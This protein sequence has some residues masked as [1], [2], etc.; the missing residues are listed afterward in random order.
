VPQEERSFDAHALVVGVSAYDRIDVLPAVQDAPDVAAVLGDPALCAYPRERVE[1]LVDAAA[2]RDAILRGLD[3]LTAAAGPDASVF[4]YFSGHGGRISDDPGSDCYLMP[5]E[6][7]WRSA[8]DLERTAIAGRELSDRL[9]GIGAARITMVLD[10]CR[11]AG[12][13]RPGPTPPPSPLDGQLTS[14]D[15]A[16]LARGRGRVVLAASRADAV[17]Y[18]AAGARNSPFTANLLAGLRGKANGTGGVI[19]ICDL[20]DYVQQQMKAAKPP[21]IPV[22]KAELEEN[23]PVALHEGGVAPALVLP[24]PPDDCAFDAFVSYRRVAADRAWV[25]Q[26]L[27]PALERLGLRLCLPERDFRLG[28]PRIREMERAVETSRY[29]LGVFT[30]QYL[31]GAFE[32][33]QALMAQHQGIEDKAPRFLP[34]MREPCRPALGIRTVEWLDVSESALE[35]ATLSRLAL[36]LREPRRQPFSR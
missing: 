10:C 15:V 26:V 36:R 25:E 4:I 14:R 1:L 11:A 8:A 5:V 23:F 12:L 7:T 31:D 30:P 35:G 3:K 6:A 17:A 2:R 13:A 24:P 33:F 32:E 21:Q 22:F 19:R 9:L 18:A 28:A 20:F 16:P 29:T 34:L 27:V